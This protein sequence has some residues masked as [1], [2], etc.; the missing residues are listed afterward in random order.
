MTSDPYHCKSLVLE[1]AKFLPSVRL[2]VPLPFRD[3]DTH[4]QP[5]SVLEKKC[6]H[7]VSCLFDRCTL[8]CPSANNHTVTHVSLFPPQHIFSKIRRSLQ[9]TPE[10]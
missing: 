7:A 9:T 3:K 6:R 8:P 1:I 10:S 4:L 5:F 2:S